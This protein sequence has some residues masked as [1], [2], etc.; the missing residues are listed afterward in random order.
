MLSFW[1]ANNVFK[2]VNVEF[3]RANVEFWRANNVFK[4]VIP[5]AIRQR[6]VKELPLPADLLKRSSKKL[7]LGRR[8]DRVQHLLTRA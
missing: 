6:D 3:W 8:V 4:H 5:R 7:G 2:R 1:R